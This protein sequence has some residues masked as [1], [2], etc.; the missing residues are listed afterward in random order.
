MP[1]SGDVTARCGGDFVDD[2]YTITDPLPASIPLHNITHL[3]CFK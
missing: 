2:I 3:G 1:C